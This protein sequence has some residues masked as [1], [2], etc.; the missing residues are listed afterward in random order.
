MPRKNSSRATLNLANPGLLW[1]ATTFSLCAR[2]G[3]THRL[4][5]LSIEW[6]TTN[7]DFERL[8]LP[9]SEASD[10]QKAHGPNA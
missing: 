8:T 9:C 4:K 2:Q 10:A 6:K 1:V 3:T 5:R 7:V